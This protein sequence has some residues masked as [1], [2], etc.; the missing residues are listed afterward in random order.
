MLLLLVT[1]EVGSPVTTISNIM[2][3]KLVTSDNVILSR[4]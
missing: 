4:Y 3:L 1:N 2:L